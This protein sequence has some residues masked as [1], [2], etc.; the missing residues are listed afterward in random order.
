[1]NPQYEPLLFYRIEKIPIYFRFLIKAYYVLDRCDCKLDEHRCILTKD[2]HLKCH[3]W[4]HIGND[5]R[6]QWC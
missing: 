4:P 5:G 2:E 1:M 3:N 6:L